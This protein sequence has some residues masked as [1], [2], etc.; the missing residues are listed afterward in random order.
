MSAF[1]VPALRV[2]V[3]G[4]LG[5][6][7]GYLWWCSLLWQAA[8]LGPRVIAEVEPLLSLGVPLFVLM[9][10]VYPTLSREKNGPWI[11]VEAFSFL[12]CAFLAMPTITF[13][14]SFVRINPDAEEALVPLALI[15]FFISVPSLGILA[16]QLFFSWLNRR[17]GWPPPPIEPPPS[18]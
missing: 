12:A 7:V 13:L 17:S 1:V 6:A 9:G 3:G 11:H 4:I 2:S 18:S 10:M 15:P 16:S 5:G 14:A 8:A